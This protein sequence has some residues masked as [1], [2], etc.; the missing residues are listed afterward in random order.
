MCFTILSR[1][2]LSRTLHK[3]D[4][5][6]I[7]RQ[8]LGSD[9][10]FFLNIG[11][12]IACFQPNGTSPLLIHTLNSLV[13]GTYICCA[14]SYIIHV[15]LGWIPSGPRDLHVL[16]VH[17]FN[18]S[19]VVFIVHFHIL[20]SINVKSWPFFYKLAV[21]SFFLF[22]FVKSYIG[23]TLAAFIFQAYSPIPAIYLLINTQS[24]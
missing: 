23:V 12:I 6:L 21:L 19:L 15:I 16:I 7:G 8:L 11:D 1:M 24:G 13:I 18:C 14:N 9:L 4:V 20:H 17:L 3:T 2:H 10:S 22:C 5:K